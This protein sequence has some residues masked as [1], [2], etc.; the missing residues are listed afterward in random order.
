[1]GGSVLANLERCRFAGDIHLVS[2]SRPEINGRPCLPSIDDLPHG[3][4]AAVLVVPQTA[5]LDAIAACG[6]RG[7]G[8]AI[9]FASGYAETGEAGRAEQEKLAAAARAATGRDAR[10]ELH[11][12]FQLRGRRGAQLRV[13]CRAPAGERAADHR[14]R[15]A[16]RRDRRHHAHGVPRQGPRPLACH[17]DRQRGGPDRRGFSRGADRGCR[18]AGRD[19]VRRADPAAGKVSRTGAARARDAQAD[20]ADASGPQPARARFGK[21]AYRRARG[22]SCGDDGAAASRRRH[23]GRDAGRAGRHRRAAGA[24]ASRR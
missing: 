22:R 16:E 21:L 9:V 18:D 24:L 5:V 15:G 10:A 1:M 12:P 17:L 6:R 8:A 23:R 14:D 3:V 20:R 19:V 2:R 11:R 4:D 7:V 13:Q